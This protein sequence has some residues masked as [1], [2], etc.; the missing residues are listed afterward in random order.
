MKNFCIDILPNLKLL[1]SS[2]DDFVT[3]E[4]VVQREGHIYANSYVI[5]ETNSK[6]RWKVNFNL[7]KNSMVPIYQ[8]YVNY[9]TIKNLTSYFNSG[10]VQN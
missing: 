6:V 7:I 1:F 8:L 10:K 9:K 5:K 3:P 2:L 4:K